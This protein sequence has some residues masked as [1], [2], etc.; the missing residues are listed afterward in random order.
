MPTATVP[1]QPC[2]DTRFPPSERGFLL[3]EPRIGQGVIE[4]LEEV[5]VHS[6]AQLA[7]LGPS[8]VVRRICEGQG[9]LAWSNRRRALERA[10]QRSRQIGLFSADAPA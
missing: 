6:L 2:T 4:R 9:S 10:L 3:A 7:A 5:G 8:V 1:A